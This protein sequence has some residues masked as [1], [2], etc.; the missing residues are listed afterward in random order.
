MSTAALWTTPRRAPR[1]YVPHTTCTPSSRAASWIGSVTGPGTSLTTSQSSSGD[2]PVTKPVDAVSGRTTSSAPVAATQRR[3]QSA[4]LAQL[5]ATVAGVSGAG[6]GA[7]W[8]AA[9]VNARIGPSCGVGPASVRRPAGAPVYE[10]AAVTSG[11]S[12]GRGE[13]AAYVQKACSI[14]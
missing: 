10:R 13:P 9:T 3:S 5:A 2:V 14:G 6:E 4:P 7:I 1:S 8:T 12:H 11:P